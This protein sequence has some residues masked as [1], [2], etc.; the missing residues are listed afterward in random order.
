MKPY[1]IAAAFLFLLL[2]FPANAA[3]PWELLPADN[4]ISGWTIDPDDTVYRQIT[5]VP[6]LYDAIDGGADVWADRSFREGSIVGYINQSKTLR[7]YL[8]D[9][10]TADLAIAVYN[11]DHVKGL[12]YLTID[13]IGDSACV[14]TALYS[15]GFQII[16]NQYYL[17]IE[18]LAKDAAGYNI[19]VTFAK[20]IIQKIAASGIIRRNDESYNK[21]IMRLMSYH[22]PA[23]SVVKIVFNTGNEKISNVSLYDIKGILVYK[24]DKVDGNTVTWNIQNVPQGIYI[25]KLA[26]TNGSLTTKLNLLK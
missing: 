24:L 11:D 20:S 7:I 4:E 3:H 16:E 17:R 19:G 23:T 2:S 15:Q 1:F 18:N 6:G 9:Q 13:T 5:S 21:A 14:D 12:C 8:Y 25:V 10:T 22:S 26:S